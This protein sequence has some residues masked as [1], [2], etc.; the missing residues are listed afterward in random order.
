MRTR[1]RKKANS[2][3]VIGADSGAQNTLPVKTPLENRI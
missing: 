1:L 3:P 2:I